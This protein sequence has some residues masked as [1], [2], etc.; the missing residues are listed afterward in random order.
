MFSIPMKYKR[1]LIAKR[2]VE[3]GKVVAEVVARQAV[4][5]PSTDRAGTEMFPRVRLH[6]QRHQ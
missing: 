1:G 2:T 3:E 4:V 6:H 5:D